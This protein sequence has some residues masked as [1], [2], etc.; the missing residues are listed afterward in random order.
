MST[1]AP[2]CWAEEREHTHL[3]YFLCHHSTRGIGGTGGRKYCLLSKLSHQSLNINWVFLLKSPEI[4]DSDDENN[5]KES[6]DR[7]MVQR[8][9]SFLTM[10]V[11][12]CNCGSFVGCYTTDFVLVFVCCLL[13][14]VDELLNET[15]Q[16]TTN[17]PKLA[18]LL[19]LKST[20][21]QS[22]R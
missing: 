1:E 8:R 15:T 13:N 2:S 19:L 9:P 7:N 4:E 10:F 17:F 20:T 22:L 16:L 18:F 6:S 11:Y 12:S 3:H 21:C 5:T 14:I